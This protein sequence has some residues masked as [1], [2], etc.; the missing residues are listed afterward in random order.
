MDIALDQVLVWL[1]QPA[2][3]ENAR[4]KGLDL[5]AQSRGAAQ[6]YARAIT[7]LI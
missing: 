4:Q 2:A 7:E 1:S 3:L 6:R 5:V